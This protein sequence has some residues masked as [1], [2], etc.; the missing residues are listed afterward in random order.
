MT[1]IKTVTISI[2]RGDSVLTVEMGLW[3]GTWVALEAIDED[4][5]LVDVTREELRILRDR[6]IDGEDETGVDD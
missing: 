1:P 2:A 3:K 5:V 4:G 6:A